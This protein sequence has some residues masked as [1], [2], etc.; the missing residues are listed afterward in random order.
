MEILILGLARGAVYA[1]VAV[2]FV[3]VFSVGGILNLAHGALFMLG[4]Y[5]TYIFYE[6]VFGAAGTPAL[7]AAIVSSIAAV[8]LVSMFLYVVVFR[9]NINS[10]S[11]VMVISLAVA[12]FVEQVMKLMFG[13]TSTGVPALVR[14]S[15]DI[16][17]VRVLTVELLLLPISLTTLGALWGFLR[18]SRTGRAIEAV[19]QNRD[20]A[21]LI[22]INPNTVLAI[23]ILISGGLAGLAG[24]LISS[25]VT[26]TPSIWSFWLVKAFAIAILGGLGSLFGAIVAAFLL[27]FVEIATTFIFTDQFADLVAL[28]VIVTI[29]VLRPSGIMGTRGV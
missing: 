28:V 7:L 24:S 6:F 22:G 21:I 11:Y 15:Q 14:G 26:V 13:V 23:S 3:L 27:S 25:L 18:F 5:F 16:L 12:L 17:G 8:C 2:G 1:L 10:V 29:L 19:A 4:A 20:G 9:R